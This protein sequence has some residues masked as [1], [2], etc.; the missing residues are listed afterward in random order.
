MGQAGAA[1]MGALNAR[2]VTQ[3]SVVRP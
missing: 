1:F 3:R 2:R